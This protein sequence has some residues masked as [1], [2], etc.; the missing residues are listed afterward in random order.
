MQCKKVI[1]IFE[2]YVR[3]PGVKSNSVS[4]SIIGNVD[5][6]PTLLD[7]A[8]VDRTELNDGKSF[9]KQLIGENV[10]NWREVILIEYMG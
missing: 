3:G 1:F 9:S 2:F 7:L 6:M 5:I 10:N 4:E 8:G